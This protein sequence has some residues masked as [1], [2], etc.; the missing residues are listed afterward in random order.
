MKILVS[1]A[2]GLVGSVL[3]PRFRAA[4][5][6]VKAL[7]RETSG[8]GS[9]GIL[10]NAATGELDQEALQRWGGP[11][12]LI[13]LAGENIAGRRWTREQ[14]LRIRESRVEATER[15]VK[16]LLQTPLKRFIGASAIG[17]Y[18]DR[19]DEEL[20]ESSPRGEG[21]LA[22]TCE[23]WEKAAGPLSAN[24][25]RVAHLRF[26][27][28]LS[29]SGGALAKMLPVFR[30]GAGGRVGT[31]RQWV[32]WISLEDVV[33]AFEFLIEERSADGIFNVVTPNPVRNAE[34]ARMLGAALNRPAVMPVPAMAVRAI[35]GEMA[36]AVLLSSQRVR[37]ERLQKMGFRFALPT[38]P[39]ALRAIL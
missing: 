16:S 2:T 37:P 23:R 34:F 19:G 9:G 31:G 30:L 13:H 28:I 3:L 17:F 4:G 21:F 38:L 12:A 29:G 25:V 8:I 39:E 14:K 20:I 33:R 36:D 22:D 32:S 26:G 6:E 11:E 7:A 24:G 5:H 35:F 27:M 10:W 1:G 15:L 18:G